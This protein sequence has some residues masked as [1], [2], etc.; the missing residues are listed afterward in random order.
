MVPEVCTPRPT[1]Q[2]DK[3]EAAGSK[4][5]THFCVACAQIL[6]LVMTRHRPFFWRMEDRVFTQK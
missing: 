2:T 6:M 4:E 3:L 1:I 5:K